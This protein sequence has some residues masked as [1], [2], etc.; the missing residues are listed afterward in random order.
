MIRPAILVALALLLPTALGRSPVRA[1]SVVLDQLD[2]EGRESDLRV[3]LRNKHPEDYY[4]PRADRTVLF[5]HG[6]TFPGS[7]SFDLALDGTSWMDW[8]ARRGYDVYALDIRG[9]GRSGRPAAMAGPAEAAP[10]AVDTA[11]ALKDVSKAVDYIASRR[12]VQRVTLVG[13]SW[14]ATLAGL[15]ATEA[16]TRV[17]RLVLLAPQW[18]RPAP[19]VEA[20]ALGAWR[21]IRLDGLRERWLRDVPEPERK[22]LVPTAWQ[23]AWIEALKHSDPVGAAMDPP[24]L[25][26]P[27]GVAADALATWAAG[28]PAWDPAR[29]SVPTLVVQGEWDVDS[30]PAMGL[31]VFA[32][33]SRAPQRRYVLVGEATHMVMLEKNREQLFRAVQGFLEER[34]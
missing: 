7:A 29:I 22:D 17:E 18:L 12:G 25:K 2:F 24:A 1:A 11:T 10:P 13:W 6:G 19:A 21:A 28:K 34:F 14:G 8:M 30:P 20:G 5:V 15:Y 23:A 16:G 4:E 26:V 32:K 31:A 3:T 27:N 33:L 9:Y